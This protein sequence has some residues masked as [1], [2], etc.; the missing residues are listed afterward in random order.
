M[1]TLTVIAK[2]VARRDRVE[3]VKAEL[4]KLVAP[5]RR[6]EGCIE[7]KLHQDN[8]DSALFMFYENWESPACLERHM[9]TPHFKEYIAAI[10]GQLAEKD[11]HKMTALG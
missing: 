9:Q 10:D 5:T 11:V 6:E 2:V 4:L 8:Q 1:S 3:A 7:Y